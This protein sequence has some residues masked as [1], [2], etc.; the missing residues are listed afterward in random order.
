MRGLILPI[1]TYLLSACSAA[2][3]PQHAQLM[4]QTEKQIRMP[5]GSHPLAEYAR[6]YAFDKN[7]R[8]IAIYTT[9][10]E[11]DYASLNLPVGQ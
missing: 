3:E 9:W 4:N 8:V 1:A 7:G 2:E 10:F 5:A 6:Y 11:P